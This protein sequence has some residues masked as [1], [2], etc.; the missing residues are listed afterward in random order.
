MFQSFLYYIVEFA[1]FFAP[2][3]FI[4]SYIA[5]YTDI[6]LKTIFFLYFVNLFLFFFSNN[7]IWIFSYRQISILAIINNQH[8]NIL[9]LILFPFLHILPLILSIY[10]IFLRI[11]YISDNYLNLYHLV[12]KLD[13]F[14][15]FY[16]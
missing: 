10:L 4:S 12:L 8:R 1:P 7:I 13:K 2:Y 15:I 6:C 11:F 14:H 3:Y 5:S 16:W 9:I